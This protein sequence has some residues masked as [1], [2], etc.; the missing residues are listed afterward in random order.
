[1]LHRSPEMGIKYE[2]HCMGDKNG[3]K[4]GNPYGQQLR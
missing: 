4:N 2:I 1:M 3:K